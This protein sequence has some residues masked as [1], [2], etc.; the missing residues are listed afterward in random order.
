MRRA[1]GIAILVI[2]ASA[3]ATRATAAPLAV[4]SGWQKVD[5]NCGIGQI[6]GNPLC[7]DTPVDGS[8]SFTLLTPG[9]LTLTDMFTSGDEFALSLNGGGQT[10]TSP[11]PPADF[12]FEPAGCAGNFQQ[13]GCAYGFPDQSDMTRFNSLASSFLGFG[14]YSSLQLALSPGSYELRIFLTAQAP[15]TFTADPADLQA[16]GLGPSGSTPFRSPPRCCCSVQG[17]PVWRT[18]FGAR[19]R[20]RFQ[21]FGARAESGGK[22]KAFD[23]GPT[24]R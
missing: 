20:T 19:R 9:I 8:Y 11:V 21:A 14:K 6:G 7:G 4:D 15:D 13:A 17:W 16:A 10:P 5:W 22:S 3:L 23:S 1:S 2:L 12:G 24:G 18:D